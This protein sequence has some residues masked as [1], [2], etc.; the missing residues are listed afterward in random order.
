MTLGMTGFWG[1]QFINDSCRNADVVFGLGT[2]FKEADCSSWENEYTF[3]IPKSKLLQV[4]IDPN[5]IGRNYPVEIGAVADLKQAL[6]VLN[7]VAKNLYPE[8]RSDTVVRRDIQLSRGV[9]RRERKIG[10]KRQVSIPARTH[11][12]RC[13]LS[14]AARRDHHNGRRLEQEWR[15]TAISHI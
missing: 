4:D 7:R 6:S 15:G 9:P 14:S 2:S 5:E 12:R 8:G 1:T 11:S 3:N 10:G 13:A